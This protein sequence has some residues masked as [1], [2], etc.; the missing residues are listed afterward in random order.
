M[1]SRRRGRLASS[2][3][4]HRPQEPQDQVVTDHCFFALRDSVT[5]ANSALPL[6]SIDKQ[7]R[8]L[9]LVTAGRSTETTERRRTALSIFC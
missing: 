6:R 3:R 2:A 8:R 4:S 5:L 1:G 7:S 9:L